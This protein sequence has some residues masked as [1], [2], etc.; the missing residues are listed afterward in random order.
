[1]ILN[2]G[3]CPAVS[4][5]QI[6][7]QI[8]QALIWVYRNIEHFGADPH[9]MQ[10]S[11]HSAGGHLLAT[12]LTRDWSEWGLQQAPLKRMNALSGL[13]DLRP[14]LQ[15]SINQALGLDP[16][17]AQDNSPLLQSI[18]IASPDLQL[19]LL[20][21]ELESDEYKRQSLELF[22]QWQ[23]HFSMHNQIAGDTHHFS[24]L[25]AFVEHFYR[26]LDPM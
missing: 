11:G 2:Y 21:G 7:Q 22:E 15:T 19:N 13:Y 12:L 4:I 14:L 26:P 18:D 6:S 24:I 1:V 3:L 25:D 20:V 8:Y 10:I 16:K 23:R 9:N 17:S 5:A